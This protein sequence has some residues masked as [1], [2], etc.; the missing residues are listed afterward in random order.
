MPPACP[1]E[2]STLPSIQWSANGSDLIWRLLGHVQ[3]KE[4]FLVLFGKQDP[5]ENTSGD[6]K[7]KVFERIASK[8]FPDE[9]QEHP[10]T[11]GKR[12]KGKVEDLCKIYKNKSLLLRQTGGGVGAPEDVGADGVHHYLDY[13]I[14]TEGPHHDTPEAAKNLWALIT[15]DFPFFAELHKFLSTRPNVVPPVIT[16]GTGPR[17]RQVIHNQQAEPSTQN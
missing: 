2:K 10:K 9:Y 15:K 11:L 1:K 7:I 4:N 16:T 12:V 13:Y 5:K 6:N 17:G 14:P 8:L 3:E